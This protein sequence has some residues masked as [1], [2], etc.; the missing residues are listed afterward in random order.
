MAQGAGEGPDAEIFGAIFDMDGVLIDSY[1]AHFQSWRDLAAELGVEVLES[2]FVRHFGRTSREIVEAYWGIGRLTDEQI[3]ELDA[4][5]EAHFRRIISSCFPEMPGARKLLKD[6]HQSGFK[7]ALG[8]SGPPENVYLVLEK[9]DARPLFEAI[10]TGMDVTR[11]KPDP[12]VF[13]LAAARLGLPPARC[14]VI[15]DAPVGIQAARAAGM[16]AVGLAS[17]G[18]TRESLAEADLVVD[19][20]EALHPTILRELIGKRNRL[21]YAT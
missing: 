19:S 16:T 14:V 20:L 9:L 10:V 8:S 7:L 15:E 13:L 18:R 11:G 21:A 2:D 3:R 12:Q 1:H 17:T 6:L 5:K 4:R